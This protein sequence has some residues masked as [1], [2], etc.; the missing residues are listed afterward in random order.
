MDNILKALGLGPIEVDLSFYERMENNNEISRIE[1]IERNNTIIECPKCG[2]TGNVGNMR[3][4]HFDNCRTILRTCKQCNNTIPIVKPYVRY[5]QMDYCNSQCYFESKVGKQPVHVARNGGKL[6]DAC[7]A[8]I[9]ANIGPE[10]RQ[11]RSERM[12]KVKPWL[13]SR[14]GRN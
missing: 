11:K 1:A 13:T 5:A 8:K 2:T 4:W 9:R 10:E 7:K 14:R 6:D 12:K 3:R